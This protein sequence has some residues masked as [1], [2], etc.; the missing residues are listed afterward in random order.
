[1]SGAIQSGE[2]EIHSNKPG[3]TK[4]LGKLKRYTNQVKTKLL[5]SFSKR[6]LSSSDSED[7]NEMSR[8]LSSKTPAGK[9]RSPKGLMSGSPFN[10]PNVH[11]ISSV[12]Y[13]PPLI[14]YSFGHADLR[15]FS[16]RNT[17]ISHAPK[18]SLD[19]C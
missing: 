19:Q 12:H 11:E 1:M 4:V 14:K 5:S 3:K 9:D 18:F 13:G 17:R 8:Q 16:F 10:Q 6:T 2:T 7:S 15:E